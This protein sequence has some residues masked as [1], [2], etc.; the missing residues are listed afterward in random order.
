ME[1]QLRDPKIVMKLSKLGSFH[2]SKLSFLRS[3]LKEFKNWKHKRDLFELDENGHGRAVYSLSKNNRTYS[4]VCFANQIKKEENRAMTAEEKKDL[5]DSFMLGEAERYF[6]T[7]AEGEPNAFTFTVESDGRIAPH[8]I[9]Y[10]ALELLDSKIDAFMEKI[11]GDQEL[12]IQ[13]SDSIMLSY[14]FIFENE[15]YTLSYLYQHYLYQLFQ[16]VEEPKIKNVSCNIPHPLENKMVIRVAL[17][18]SSLH[19]DYIKSSCVDVS[20]DDLETLVHRAINL[21]CSNLGYY[22]AQVYFIDDLGEFAILTYSRGELGEKLLEVGH[23][24]ALSQ[25]SNSLVVS[26][27][28]LNIKNIICNTLDLGTVLSTICSYS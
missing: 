26:S 25:E 4:L 8:N 10:Q 22:H 27:K 17:R 13:K 15:D 5:E 11:S 2:Q 9:F 16:N 28:S 23:R 24:I 20:I 7:D 3:F 18:D 6:M 19:S 21:I 12:E 1:V 14:D